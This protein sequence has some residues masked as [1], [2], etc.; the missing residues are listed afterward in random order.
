MESPSP[1]RPSDL[2][3]LL[4]WASHALR[5]EHAAGMAELGISP[6]AY[7]VLLRARGGDL[8]QRQIG[9]LCGVDKTTMVVTLDQ[10]EA[11]G[12]ARRVPA[13]SDRRA[14][15]VEVTPQG[16]RV[17]DQARQIAAR[18]E[19]DVLATLPEADREVFL[20]AIRRLVDER[21]S[22]ARTSGVAGSVC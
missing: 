1:G 16:E 13:P 3:F 19:T 4:S 5:A 2:M 10:L 20:R 15:L 22:G 18:L 21:L 12:L 6:R 11:S 14:R 9:E 8:T 7:G 17:L